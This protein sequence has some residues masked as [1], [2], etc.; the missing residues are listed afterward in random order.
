MEV[1][2]EVKSMKEDKEMKIWRKNH[3]VEKKEWS[4]GREKWDGVRRISKSMEK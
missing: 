2:N 4:Y 3:T 1:E